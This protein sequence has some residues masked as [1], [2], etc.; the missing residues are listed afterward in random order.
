MN[1]PTNIRNQKIES[2][3]IAWLRFGTL[4]PQKALLQLVQALTD[5]D[6]DAENVALD[7]LANPPACTAEAMGFYP[8]GDESDF[9]RSFRG[10]VSMLGER[11]FLKVLE[12]KYASHGVASWLD[13]GLLPPDRLD[14]ETLQFW[15][16]FGIGDWEK[17]SVRT[18]LKRS[19]EQSL[20][21][22]AI[23]LGDALK[24]VGMA[25]LSIELGNGGDTI[26]ACTLPIEHAQRW[27]DVEFLRLPSGGSLAIRRF[28][29]E[30]F[31]SFLEYSLNPEPLELVLPPQLLE[32][33]LRA[34]QST[35]N[36]KMTIPRRRKPKGGE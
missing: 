10:I 3:T 4:D 32:R 36:P 34:L 24:E 20:I 17:S 7:L 19:L 14:A 26:Y 18:R 25:L 16:D 22:A 27:R 1:R 8:R 13:Q 11:R 12:D 15:N 31:F 9:E 33:P 23:Q 30:R 29:W 6:K 21:P 28:H 5:G 35:P 2:T